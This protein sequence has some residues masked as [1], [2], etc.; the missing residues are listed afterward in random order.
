MLRSGGA[1]R[2]GG[3]LLALLLLL[4]GCQRPAAAQEVSKKAAVSG[5]PSLQLDFPPN[6]NRDN[7]PVMT[8]TKVTI[9]GRDV[10]YEIP[11]RVKGTLIFFHG[12][13]HNAYDFWYKQSA[14]PEC[15]GA[16][17][18]SRQRLWASASSS[19]ALATLGGD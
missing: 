14:C 7:D 5:T 19:K 8:P 12:C 17:W 3:A 1:G 9:A 10:Y 15:R 18:R 2:H 11:Q 13:V 4:A 16:Q 6:R